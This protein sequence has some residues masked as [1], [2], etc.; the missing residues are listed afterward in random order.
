MPCV[1]SPSKKKNN[2]V[3]I[4][5][6]RNNV[7]IKFLFL[8]LSPF[9]VLLSFPKIEKRNL[10]PEAVSVSCFSFW[11]PESD[12]FID[13][14]VLGGRIGEEKEEKEKQ[15]L[16]QPQN[17]VVVVTTRRP[18]RYAKRKGIHLARSGQ[19]PIQTRNRKRKKE[20]F[21]HEKK[22]QIEL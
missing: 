3:L 21:Y 22:K 20:I 7:S 2:V 15:Q 14:Y 1:P 5:G 16:Q 12:Y 18:V 4:D 17:I 6:A 8:F 19:T 13:T 10:Q 11:V 9:F